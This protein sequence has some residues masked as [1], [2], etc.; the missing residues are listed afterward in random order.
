MNK[1]EKLDTDKL[2]FA[3]LGFL[4][5]HDATTKIKAV[6]CKTI[7]SK[8]EIINYKTLCRRL[9]KL[10]S[11]G[12]INTGTPESREKTYYITKDGEQKLNEIM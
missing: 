4:N 7:L 1:L 3:L 10:I 6:T 9:S 11:K 8:L 2:D 12:Y 5:A